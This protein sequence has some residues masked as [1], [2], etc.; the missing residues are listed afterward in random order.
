MKSMKHGKKFLM[1][2]GLLGF[3]ASFQPLAYAYLD[4]GSGSY[5]FQ[6]LLSFMVGALFSLKIFWK[7][8]AGFFS[9]I[10]KEKKGAKP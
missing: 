1:V 3:I 10:F 7:K 9:E 4:P 6:I 5:L 2:I 8:I